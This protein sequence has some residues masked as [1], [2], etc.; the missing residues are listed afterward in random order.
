MINKIQTSTANDTPRYTG[1][2][3]SALPTP[4]AAQW[5]PTPTIVNPI[6]V[7]TVPVTIGGK[8]RNSL[9]TMGASRVPITPAAI[10]AP[11][12]PVK[13]RAG[14]VTIASIGP[15]QQTSPP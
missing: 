1:L 14:L 15:T 8:K 12:T 11:K 3:Y 13:P 2:P 6:E 4:P 9:P 10:V 7:I 5:M